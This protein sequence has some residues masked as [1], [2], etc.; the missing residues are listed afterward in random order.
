MLT[1]FIMLD[2]QYN[3]LMCNIAIIYLPTST[4]YCSSTTLGNMGYSSKGLAGQSHVDARKLML[5]LCQDAWALFSSILA[6]RLMAVII[7]TSKRCS[8]CCHPFV[9]LLVTL[10]YSSETMHQPIVRVRR[11]S[12]FSVKRWNSLLQTYGLQIILI[13]T[14]WSIECEMLCRIVFIRRQ[15][16]TWPIYSS[17]WLTHGT[18]WRRVSLMMLS[19]NGWRDLGPAW[20]KRAGGHLEHFLWQL[21]LKTLGYAVTGK[22][23]VCI[24]CNSIVCVLSL[25]V[26]LCTWL[27]PKVV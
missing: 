25:H 6:L 19:T 1:Y 8:R 2:T 7:T 5:Y 14:T 17:A 11:S 9:P 15:F 26:S 12:C 24:L 23:V 3:E 16:E 27:F 4:T 18:D 10:M 22:R 13:L 20:R 21:N